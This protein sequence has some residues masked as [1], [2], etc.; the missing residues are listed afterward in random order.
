[1][2]RRLKQLLYTIFYLVLWT[3]IGALIYYVFL[4][5]APSCFDNKQ[6]QGEEGIDCGGPCEKICIPE[7]VRTIE[8]L[9]PVKLFWLDSNHVNLLATIQ[10]GNPGFAAS[11][12]TY[13]FLV[14]NKSDML[15]KTLSGDSFI[16]SDEVK[17]IPLLNV[18]LS[19]Q[20]VSR[21]EFV[22][23]NINWMKTNEFGK[24]NI[25]LVS[26]T[27]RIDKNQII[28]EGKITNMD[29]VALDHAE[30]VALFQSE[31]GPLAGVSKTELSTVGP[32]QTV[33]FTILHPLLS[34]VN[35]QATKIFINTPRP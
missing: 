12:F 17:Q 34:N 6:N 35:L 30:I 22:S 33:D 28:V 25:K 11:H 21:V 2:H 16:Y 20:S 27:A 18:E 15:V 5:P 14:F 4:V 7:S 24:P 3:G 23:K 10:N 13:Q 32:N 26:Q 1:M 9:N 19:R 31:I 29:S 8:L